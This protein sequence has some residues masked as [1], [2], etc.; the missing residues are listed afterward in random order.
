MYT[1]V[2]LKTVNL[3]ILS[4]VLSACGSYARQPDWVDKP[5]TDYPADTYL[6]TVGEA[7]NREAADSRARAN[8]GQI[9]RVAIKDSSQDFSQAIVS[10]SD[11]QQQVA[12]QQRAARFVSTEARQVLEGTEIVAYW[13][14][15]LGKVYSLAVLEKATASRRFREHLRAADRQ[16]VD[17]VGYASDQAP[18]P[19]VAL[20]ALE[21]AR[22]SQVERDNAN[23]NLMITAGKGVA[24]RYSGEKIVGLIRQALA[25]L[26]FTV[27]ADDRIIQAELENAVAS[28]GIQQV[29]QS[30]YV[31]SSKLDIEP[32]QQKQG[33]WW[34][35]GSLQLELANSGETIAKQR[36]PIKQ[37][38][39]EKGLTKQRLQDAVNKKLSG[40][41]YDMLTMTPVK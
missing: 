9:F 21:S 16:T 27:S 36:W 28:L 19:V 32:L 15:P 40:Y 37:S 13:S 29:V 20:R 6:S 7:D 10:N 23:R 25:T 12:N 22:L 33:W 4:L 3:F 41:L 2:S 8:L 18:N 38:S 39:T 31:L 24:G 34:L 26:Q 30:S 11:G 14:S 17:L 1:A 35:R 5:S